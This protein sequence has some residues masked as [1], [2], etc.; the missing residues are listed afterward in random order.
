MKM[1]DNHNHNDNGYPKIKM[2]II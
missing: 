1:N 2:I